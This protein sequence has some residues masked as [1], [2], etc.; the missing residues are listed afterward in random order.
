M[1]SLDWVLAYFQH[2]LVRVKTSSE[3]LLSTARPPGRRG[4][5]Q[6]DVLSG[7]YAIV[8]DGVE[9]RVRRARAESRTCAWAR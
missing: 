4:D 9:G 3:T 6:Y 1:I 8:D 2:L 7:R 5:T